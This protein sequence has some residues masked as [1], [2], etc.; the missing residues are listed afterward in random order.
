MPA[1]GTLRQRKAALHLVGKGGSVTAAMRAAGYKEATINTPSKLTQSKAFKEIFKMDVSDDDLSKGHK[2]LLERAKIERWT[3]P[4]TRVK[5]RLI[6]ISDD[7]VKDII[8]SVRGQKLVYIQKTRYE[9]IAYYQVPESI[10][11]KSAIEMAYKIR[12]YFSP[13]KLE[14]VDDEMTPEEEAEFNKIYNQNKKIK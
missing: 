14:I 2:E 12:G 11:R 13:D 10:V 5:K 7:K 4:T 8:E 9:K 3:F 6:H 1:P